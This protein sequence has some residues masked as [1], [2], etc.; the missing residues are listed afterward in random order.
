MQ[1][2]IGR[3]SLKLK[4]VQRALIRAKADLFR[5]KISKR[6]RGSEPAIANRIRMLTA[7]VGKLTTEIAKFEK[8]NETFTLEIKTLRRIENK[9]FRQA[10]RHTGSK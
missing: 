6:L 10:L 9:L 7:L 1:F 4:A 5:A 2:L 8:F 3:K